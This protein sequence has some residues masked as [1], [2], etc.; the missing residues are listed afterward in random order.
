MNVCIIVKYAAILGGLIFLSIPIITTLTSP[1]TS[2]L[3]QI[4]KSHSLGSIS[5]FKQLFGSDQKNQLRE[6]RSALFGVSH[7]IDF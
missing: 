6:L 2:K 4:S 3:P 1:S 7:L 5:Y